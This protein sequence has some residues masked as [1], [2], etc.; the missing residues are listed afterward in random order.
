M[1]IAALE[2]WAQ[3]LPLSRPY[4]IAFATIS[5]TEQIFVRICTDD[6]K[7][8]LGAGA[9]FPLLT[10][11]TLEDALEA[12]AP[13][14]LDWLIDRNPLDR[15][16]LC[17]EHRCN[18]PGK[19]AAAAAVD[20]ALH[21]LYGQIVGQPL[22]ETLGIEHA[23]LPTSVTI[24]IMGVEETLEAAREYLALGFRALKVKVG[25]DLEE[26]LERLCRLREVFGA[27]VTLRADANQGYDLG[28]LESFLAGTEGL[29]LELVEQ[30]VDP[31]SF[32]ELARLPERQRHL[33]AADES[34]MGPED[35]ARL[36]APTHLCGVFN[37]KLM[38]CGGI[39]SAL[40]I[41]HVAHVQHLALM[42]GCMDES[43][44]SIAA[45]LHAAFACSATRYLDL[46]GSFDLAHD[47]ATGG[48]ALKDGLM[49]ITNAPGL[50]VQ[51][52]APERVPV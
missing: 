15:E 33:I 7:V 6:G 11:E 8:G 3:A 36:V 22:A 13:E 50:G 1:S 40:D 20:I 2:V 26:D 49:T 21:D 41:A 5:A 25:R 39:S 17:R 48:F 31:E 4:T 9:P 52:I 35:C 47:I 23:A 42:W 19:P 27:A 46:D 14:R 32:G 51:L 24:G 34:L 38:K 18:C 12:L 28:T 43:V 37:I 10:G 44:I 16:A 29:D 45:A 30:P